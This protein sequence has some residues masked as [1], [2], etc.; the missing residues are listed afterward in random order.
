MTSKNLTFMNRLP[1]SDILLIGYEDDENLGLRYIAAFLKKN[2]VRVKIVPY[3]RSAR[4]TILTIVQKEKPRLIG[5][6]LIFQRMVNDFGAV[7]T[8][9]RENG[10]TSHFTIGGHYPTIQYHDVLTAIPGLDTVVRHEGEETLLELYR[11]VDRPDLWS[12]VRGIAFRSNDGVVATPPRELIADLDSLPFPLRAK[13][14]RDYLGLGMASVLTSRGCYYDCSFCSI[15]RF[16]SDAPGPMRRSRTPSNVIAE[17]SELYT[18]GVRIFNFRDDDFS[19]KGKPRQQWIQEFASGLAEKGL[20]DE[21]LWRIS[22]RVDEV[23]PGW[24]R[25]LMDAGLGFLYLGIESGCE[26]GL[27]TCNKH[28]SEN[29]V[30]QTLTRLEKADLSFDYGFMLL[31]PDTDFTSVKKNLEFLQELGK[32]GRVSVHFTKM[33]PYAGTPIEARLIKEGRLTGTAASPAYRYGDPRIDLLERFITRSFSHMLFDPQGL[34]YKFQFAQFSSVV[35]E[36][37][38]SDILDFKSYSRSVKALTAECNAS[39]LGTLGAAVRFMEPR[40]YE[41][42]TRDWDVLEQLTKKERNAQVKILAELDRLT[43]AGPSL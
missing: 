40:T 25:H 5:F 3:R 34:V 38:F 4:K 2:G 14:F 39:V 16:Y 1:S 37:F 24:M 21:I 27:K 31:D 7:I 17:L 36:R 13:K 43:P 42:I 32:G 15:R 28:Y 30:Y 20:S 9:L 11:N 35:L 19:M 10:V 12:H 29:D 18:K 6:S 23:D 8:Y 22:C 41:D 26:Q 33:L